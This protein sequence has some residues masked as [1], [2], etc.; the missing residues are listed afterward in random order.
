MKNYSSNS[1]IT[2]WE[3]YAV[4]NPIILSDTCEETDQTTLSDV[5]ET[6]LDLYRRGFNV[7]PLPAV[8]EW[9][10]V[11]SPNNPN[12]KPPYLVKPLFYSRLHNCDET[13]RHKGRIDF[14]PL[15]DRANIGLMMGRTSG[16][17]F[18]IDCDSQ[19]SFDSIGQEI[20]ALRL[21]YWAIQSHRGGAY[22][23]RLAEG[24]A[25]NQDKTKSSFADV[26][27]WGNRH[28]I[29]IPPSIHPQGTVYRWVTP[30]PRYSLPKGETLPTTSILA[31]DWL[32]AT[33]AIKER[34]KWQ[35][36]DL[37]GLPEWGAMLSYDN[38]MMYAN[39]AR[40]GQRNNKLTSLAYDMAGIR[41]EYNEAKEIL[42]EAAGRC[43]PSYS[44]NETL[45]ILKSAYSRRRQPA[46]KSG[47][48][49]KP[50]QQAKHFAQSYDWR[51]TFG[52]R[53]LK[54]QAVFMACVERAR[55]DN[56]EVWRA[57]KR[58]LSELANTSDST[59]WEL[60]V[61]LRNHELIFKVGQN[62]DTNAN[63]YRFGDMSKC[64]PI[65]PPCSSSGVNLDIRKTQVEQ[66]VF[67][68]LGERSWLVWKYLTTNPSKNANVIAKRTG[69]PR[70]SVYA[71]LPRLVDAKLVSYNQADNLY[72]GETR[73]D[74][75]LEYL[76]ANLG[77]LG[78]SFE[79]KR[80]HQI[81]REM[82]VNA[83]MARARQSWGKSRAK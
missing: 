83:L 75:S 40:E 31:L 50:W 52:R 27:I 67:S 42:F 60:M 61:E 64:T 47:G 35:E 82:R 12:K 46:R 53:A 9:R 33:L 78:K 54:C 56:S 80:S 44:E 69:W 2:I 62:A 26:E 39:G 18:A 4:R 22:I 6:A 3:D 8:W 48:G 13:C 76:A 71:V 59:A 10:A 37:F 81:E 66:D 79:K 17:T 58:E 14:T 38:R 73:T 77:V 41:V 55:C 29:V 51:G 11:A 23:L 19:D 43:I 68:K 21:P 1:D 63:L 65:P 16:N 20:K 49:T 15:F 72:Y 70:S 34:K 36:P 74:G 28:Y 7:F 57:S 32:G 25:S 24:E 45:A 30:E 5:Q